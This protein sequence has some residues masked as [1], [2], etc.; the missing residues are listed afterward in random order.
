MLTVTFA[1]ATKAGEVM[2]HRH[3]HTP[4]EGNLSLEL[5]ATEGDSN[6]VQAKNANTAHKALRIRPRLV[7]VRA[8]VHKRKY[9]K[10]T[11]LRSCGSTTNSGA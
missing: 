4:G 1:K 11:G 10:Q 2:G 8:Q 3:T 5:L 9:C 7:I 6:A